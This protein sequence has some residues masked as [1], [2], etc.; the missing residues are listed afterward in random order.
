M[1]AINW[2]KLLL[3]NIPYLLFV[4][5]FDK[6]GQ[7]VRLAPGADLSGKVLSLGEGFSMAFSNPL[8]SLAPM[9]LLIGILGAVLIRLIVYVKGKNA[10]KYRKGIEYGSARWGTAEDIKPYTDPV[11]QNNVLLTQTERLTMNSRP[12]QPKYA[13]NKNILVIGGSG[14]G[15]TRFFVKP[16]LMQMHSSYVVTDPK[17]TV[18]VECGKLL[19]RGGYRIKVLNTINFKKSMRMDM[20][21]NYSEDDSPLALKSDFILSLC[22]LVIGGKEGLQPVDKTVIDR[23]VRNVYRDYLADPDP[24]KMPI[25]GDLY[26]E[27]L[28]Q[29]EPEA[30]R[31][32]AALE[33]Y[34]SG[35][36]NVFNHRTNVE[37]SNR[38]VCFD[39]KQLGKQ[40]KKLGMLIVQD[41]IWNRVTINR[42]EKKSTRY[43]MDEFHLL[44]KEEQTAAYSVEIWKRF[45][46]W[47]GIPTAITQNI[48]DLL[49]SREVENI[50]ENSDFVLMLN[51]AQGDRAIL[52]KQLNISPQQMKYVTHT[53]AGEGLIFYG[54]VVLPFVDHFP[55]DTELYRI[56]TTK[57]EEVSSL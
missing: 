15:K 23:A 21:L 48:K 54:N 35:S 14:S 37:L 6:V 56:M 51:Q 38:L 30:A 41:Q 4:Y 47:G 36:L 29:P 25:L 27:L 17:G 57:P 13:R 32:A 53:E 44:L 18:L 7:A 8:P 52:A 9:D 10:K 49:A 12:K 34:V 39:I 42:A 24:A 46:K 43:Y 33:L 31:I 16:N 50:F 20:N 11:F 55:K 22:E 1:N 45:S 3:P 26:D 40:L 28:K 2:K 19:Q 5:L